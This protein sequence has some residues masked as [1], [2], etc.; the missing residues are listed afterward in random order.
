MATTTIILLFADPWILPAVVPSLVEFPI[1]GLAATVVVI[2]TPHAIRTRPRLRASCGTSPE[3]SPATRIKLLL[4][5]GRDRA[6]VGDALAVGSA[7]ALVERRV[8]LPDGEGLGQLAGSLVEGALRVLDEVW[9]RVGRALGAWEVTDS[10][11][12]GESLGLDAGEGE[13]RCQGSQG[14]DVELH[15]CVRIIRLNEWMNE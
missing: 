5:V 12:V 2:L 7:V 10:W 3:E 6:R 4:D 13:G 14:G 1:T 11:G 9:R 8:V 15:I